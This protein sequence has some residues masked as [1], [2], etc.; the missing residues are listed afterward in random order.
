[1]H[2]AKRNRWAYDEFRCDITYLLDD[3]SDIGKDIT[4]IFY[5]YVIAGKNEIKDKVLPIRVP[6]GTIGAIKIDDE[7]RITAIKLN[8]DT[9]HLVKYPKNIAQMLEK[10]VGEII[11]IPEVH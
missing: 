1:M 4:Y 9:S 7:R 11:K 8:S 2:F 6:G 10:Y 5:H 3:K